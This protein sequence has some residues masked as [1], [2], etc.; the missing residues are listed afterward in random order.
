MCTPALI[1]KTSGNDHVPLI[2]RRPRPLGG[3]LYISVFPSNILVTKMIFFRSPLLLSLTKVANLEIKRFD[4]QQAPE[5][6]HFSSSSKIIVCFALRLAEH[7]DWP[8]KAQLD[9]FFLGL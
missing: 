9:H 8:R 1:Q 3:P 4:A 7:Y 5:I 6:A 2:P